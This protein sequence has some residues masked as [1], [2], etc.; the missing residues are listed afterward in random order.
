MSEVSTWI[1]SVAGVV[2]LS[3]LIE[4]IMPDGQMNKYIKSIFS[5]V[6][7]L[8]IIL[9]LPKLFKKQNS[10][11]SVFDYE[12]INLQND[13]L[14][15]LNLSKLSSI[16]KTIEKDIKELGYNDVSLSISADIFDEKID[17]RGIYVNL[18]NLVIS[19]DFEHKNITEIKEDIT[20]VIGKYIN[21]GE[22]FFEE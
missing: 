20:Q 8:V 16:T 2:C 9:P 11:I 10:S 14:Y 21:D 4:F 12:E 6:I 1:L 19:N 15:E 3:V 7:I 5:F 22:V 18:N 17:Y 13:Y